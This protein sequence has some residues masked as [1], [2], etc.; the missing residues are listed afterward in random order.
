V[1]GALVPGAVSAAC[2]GDGRDVAG[3]A[4]GSEGTTFT[5][6]F[7]TA[8][9]EAA[10]RDDKVVAITAAMDKGTGLSPFKTRFSKR[11]FDVGIAEEHAVTFAAGL[12]ARGL[13]P[14]VAIYS[15]FIQRAADQ[16]IH[17]TSL[18]GLPVVF[19][20]DRSGCVGDDGETHQG[21]FDI[22]IF[23]SAPN[24]TILAPASGR[25]LRNMLAWALS[26]AGPVAIRYPKALCPPEE[27]AFSLPL[28]KGRGVFIRR[29]TDS[30]CL[31][32]T[33]S[34]YSQA[35][36]AAEILSRRGIEADLYNLRFL[37]PVDEDYLA[38]ILRR[39][40]TV[41]FIEEGIRQGG[42]GEY[43][44]CLAVHRNSPARILVLGVE[45]SF[46][47]LSA[48]RGTAQGSRTELLRFNRLDGP[49]I[50]SVVLK[51]MES[52]VELP[53]EVPVLNLT[54]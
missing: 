16:V 29:K 42:F 2:G 22:S 26:V 30:L 47:A 23:R 14:V 19:A 5:G 27:D 7:S 36:E 38:G 39:Y 44:A 17:D 12:A 11:F 3:K 8:L 25:E 37:K 6:S 18:Q 10:A 51:C 9:Q 53:R 4:A 28:E 45:E 41:V 46:I 1:S 31:A 33:G 32:F 52:P 34:L 50:A 43:A 15:T 54:R 35:G 21:I 49:G 13:R 48:A 20:L 40:K 24:M